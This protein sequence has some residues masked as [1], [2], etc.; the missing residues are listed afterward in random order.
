MRGLWKGDGGRVSGSPS[1]DTAWEGKGRQVELERS[2]HMRRGNTDL[3]DRVPDQGRDKGM[4][5]VGL[6]RKGPDTDVDEGS[7]LAPACLRHRDHLGGGKPPTP[8]VLTMRHA[9]PVAVPQL[10]T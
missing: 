8:K 7:F 10:E 5:S 2:S 6:P 1:D 4:P 3:L 9:G